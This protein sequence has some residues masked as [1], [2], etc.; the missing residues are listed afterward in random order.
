MN[1]GNAELLYYISTSP[2]QAGG[3]YGAGNYGAGAYGSGQVLVGQTGTP[4]TST[5]WTLGNWG[6]D[7]IACTENGGIFYWGPSSGYL[8]STMIPTAPPFNTGA[9]ISN[10]QQMV[11]AYGSSVAASIGTYQDPL[12]VKWCDVQNFFQWLPAITNQAGS[13]RIPTGSACIGGAAM[14]NGNL[15]WTDLDVWSMNYIGAQLVFGFVKAGSNCGLV[16]KH[17]WTQ[18]ANNVYWVGKNNLFVMSG[19]GVSV[20]P[21]PVW[22][23][24]FQDFDIA[25]AATCFAGSNTLHSEFW[26]FYPSLQDKLGRPS[27][28][29]KF[30]IDEGTW[31]FGPMQRNC[32]MDQSILGA[33][34]ACTNNGIIYSH[35]TGADAD[36][37]PMTSGFTTG[38][39]YVDEGE[40][41]V[42][43]DKIFP[44]FIWESVG[45]TTSANIQIIINAVRWPG[46][47]PVTYG[48]YTVTQNTP[49]IDVRIRARQ[50]SLN[51][52][53]QDSGSFW[54][55]GRIRARYTR[56]GRWG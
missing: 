7:L 44:D 20:L 52:Q 29:I 25:N 33:P 51:V 43:I 37:G 9:F 8:N 46:D 56:D 16:A 54:R 17:A 45:G 42:F 39:L 27:R 3:N 35:E 4:I 53:S 5:D 38:Y 55:L 40:D 49:Q 41:F 10:A 26:V 30:R 50:I 23:I 1:S 6:E 19:G 31:D 36:T 15:I 47:S 48:P 21:C 12:L 28:Y 24:M 11:I 32:W 34:L 18:I 14:P 2:V 13:F 22:D